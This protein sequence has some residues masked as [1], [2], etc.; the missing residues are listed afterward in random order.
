MVAPS[1]DAAWL[2]VEEGFV[3]PREHEVESVLALANG[4]LGTRGSLAEGCSMSAPATYVAG[5]FDAPL[6]A[7][8]VP[9]LALLP[10]WAHVESEID[11]V[12]LRLEGSSPVEHR[13][14]LDMRNAI[15]WRE[16]RFRD[17]A[18]RITQIRSLRL[19]SRSNRHLLIQSVTF[20][21]EN[22]SGRLTSTVPPAGVQV[23]H[24]SRGVTI[25]MVEGGAVV[26]PSGEKVPLQ[27]LSDPRVP[28]HRTAVELE[29]A[30]TYR[31]DRVVAV[32]TSRDTPQPVEEARRAVASTLE[33]ARVDAEIEAHVSAWDELWKAA[34]VRITGDDNAQRAVRFALYH[35]L[36]AGNADDPQVSI[37]A[38]ALTGGSYKGHVF[39]DTDIFM[40]PF[41]TFALPQ[42]ARALLE[43]R[44]RT[45]PAAC[46]RAAR[47]G[48]RGALYAWESADTGD[49]VTPPFVFAPDGEVVPVLA[50]TQEQHISADVAY[51]VWSYWQATGDDLFFSEQGAEILIETARFWACRVEAGDDGLF[52]IRGVIG[53]DEYHESVDDN[54][55]TNV[56]AQWNL[57]RA[58]DVAALCAVR[59]PAAWEKL[60]QR[61]G[62]APDEPPK[63]REI[64]ARMYTGFDPM[65][66][67]FEQ[68]RGYFDR[69]PIDLRGLEPRA[70]PATVLLGRERVEGSQIIKQADVLMLIHLLWDRFSP[71]VRASNYYFYE[72]RT[73]HGSSLSPAI[74]ALIAARLGELQAAE[75]YFWQTA[76]IDLGNNMGNA[77]GGVHAAALGG[78]WQA[79]VFG[80]GDVHLTEE[81]PK[82]SAP[83]LLSRWRGLDFSLFWRGR[84]FD[85][86]CGGAEG[87]EPR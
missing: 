32:Y 4:Y 76:E 60:R 41:F 86:S 55:Y 82:A 75:R 20:T 36:S 34:D 57:E 61:I 83:K 29:I 81:G 14:L 80:F 26:R 18:G 51:A 9:E 70:V 77:A 6:G 71:A 87:K 45:L 38:R 1:A 53:P 62:L 48:Y 21:P 3:L 7:S 22:Y 37:G 16:W 30:R 58:L 84:R 12:P 47:H 39:W 25:A 65:S 59:F 23:I 2:I 15:L 44:Y 40:L 69:E 68:F 33:P 46:A 28:S 50:G 66:G 27:Q 73:D 64:A 79:V 17:E 10:D 13:R 54:A 63:W 52:H 56:M 85:F 74:H 31:L 67:L 49:D 78:L 72:P 24:T 43:Y 11:G 19:A 5:V 42:T 8:V 35:L